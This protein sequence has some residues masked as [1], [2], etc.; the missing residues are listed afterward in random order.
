MAIYLEWRVKW[1]RSQYSSG[2]LLKTRKHTS[3][4]TSDLRMSSNV[5]TIFL[6]LGSQRMVLATVTS[7]EEE[8][9][10]Q[11]AKILRKSLV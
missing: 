8:F 9:H 7:E 6:L 11:L 2:A 5:D 3:S 4:A 10:K 1:N